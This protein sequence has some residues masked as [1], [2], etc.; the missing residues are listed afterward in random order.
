MLL[1]LALLAL[2]LSAPRPSQPLQPGGAHRP[3]RPAHTPAMGPPPPADSPLEKVL[4]EPVK[5]PIGPGGSPMPR[6]LEQNRRWAA[7]IAQS[8]GPCIFDKMR[9]HKPKFLW[10]G[11]ADARVPSNQL[12]GLGPG[13]VFVHRNIANLVINVDVNLMSVIQYAIDVLKVEDVIVCG[14]YECGGVRAAMESKAHGSPLENWL[15]NIKDVVRLHA[16]ELNAIPCE[17]ARYRRLVELNAIE[18]TLNVFKTA[19]VQRARADSASD[20]LSKHVT[21]RVHAVV[22]DPIGLELRELDVD[23]RSGMY[24]DVY[25]LYPSSQESLRFKAKVGEN[26][27]TRPEYFV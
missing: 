24:E 2:G 13:E 19:V 10:I 1:K 25:R 21:P 27:L 4:F 15:R 22:Y 7:E 14:H 23:F 11:C 16:D 8:E 3:A 9:E 17:E 20:P 12:L 5:A 18:Q 6:L 26:G